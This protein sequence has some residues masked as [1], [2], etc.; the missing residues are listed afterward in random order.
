MKVLFICTGSIN[1]S[2]SA[3]VILLGNDFED[4]YEVQACGTGKIAPKGCKIP[5][6]MRLVLEEMGY[7]PRQHRS[8]GI[9]EELLEWADTV[10]VMGNV[11]EKFIAKNYPQHLNK[12]EN[13][14]IDDPHFSKGSEVHKRV[15]V[16]IE[17]LILKHFP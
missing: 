4:K 14:K 13:W 6:K 15:A 10:I 2:A 9:S 1:R 5:K 3:K 8:Q 11:H 16:E 17:N 12:V 7:D